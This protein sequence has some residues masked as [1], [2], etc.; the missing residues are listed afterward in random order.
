MTR[1]SISPIL[2]ISLNEDLFRRQKSLF[3]ELVR[4]AEEAGGCTKK[5]RQRNKVNRF[6]YRGDYSFTSQ[7]R[8]NSI[9]PL[10]LLR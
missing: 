3:F 4:I 7:S 2:Y 10:R 8:L 6:R 1:C 5:S 9:L